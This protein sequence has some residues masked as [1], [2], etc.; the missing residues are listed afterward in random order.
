VGPVHSPAVTIPLQKHSKKQTTPKATEHPKN[1][2][3]QKTR[4]KKGKESDR[5]PVQ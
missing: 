2:T 3:K 4:T 1:T 5:V